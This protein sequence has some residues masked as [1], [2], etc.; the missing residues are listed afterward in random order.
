M[1]IGA[2]PNRSFHPSGSSSE[3]GFAGVLKQRSEDG[4]TLDDVSIQLA[5]GF[6]EDFLAPGILVQSVVFIA[7][8]YG[9]SAIWERDLS[10]LAKY[11][12]ARPRPLVAVAARLY[13]IISG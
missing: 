10:V 9:L 5:G 13:P 11:L 6:S 12:R 2:L 1:F 3:D 8:F 4:T 7:I